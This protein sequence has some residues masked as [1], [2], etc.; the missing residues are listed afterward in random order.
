MK[1]IKMRFASLFMAL[2]MLVG[3]VAG[4][5][6]M[7]HAAEIEPSETAEEIVITPRA[8]HD[9]L[10]PGRQAIGGFT[11]TN[12]NTTPYKIVGNGA[13]TLRFEVHFRVAPTDQG[14]GKV[15]LKMQ[16]RDTNGNALC[17]VVQAI[18]RYNPDPNNYVRGT[19]LST[20]EINV[21]PGQ[22]LHVWFDA[23]TA[24]PAESN[25]HYRSIQIVTFTSIVNE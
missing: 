12:T 17:E 19:T 14:N 2:L 7:A 23:S 10:N 13:N 1:K 16:I 4:T 18:D 15:M 8:G 21:V 22:T 20:P 24:N 25:G 6:V 5:P 3:S 11:F 9:V